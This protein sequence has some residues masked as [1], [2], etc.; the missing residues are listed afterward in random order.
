MAIVTHVVLRPFQVKG[1]TLEVGTPV[2][3]SQWKNTEGLVNTKYLRPAHDGD[4][5]ASPSKTK[6]ITLT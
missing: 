6:K 1:K 3:A 4:R 2:D 5:T